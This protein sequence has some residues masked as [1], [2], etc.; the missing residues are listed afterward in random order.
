MQLQAI[1]EGTGGSANADT[2]SKKLGYEYFVK[3][4]GLYGGA[5]LGGLNFS[6]SHKVNAAAYGAVATSTD[7][8]DGKVTKPEGLAGLTSALD[9]M[10]R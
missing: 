6:A 3:G 9:A 8:L 4:S 5:E 10:A 2:R 1:A 7:I